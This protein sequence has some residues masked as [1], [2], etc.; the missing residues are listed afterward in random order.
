MPRYIRPRIAGASVFFTVA[1]ADRSSKALIEHIDVLRS[2]VQKTRLERP[3]H[4]NA[5]VVLPD[6]LHAVWTLPEDDCDYATRWSLI[7]ARM[8]RQMPLCQRRQSHIKRREHGF[9]QRRFWEHHI[10]NEA[11]MAACVEYC[12]YNPVKHGFVDDVQD[13]PYSSWH[14][15]NGRENGAP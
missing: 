10:R 8:S 9:W 5:W 15:D 4:I 12:W 14:K 3:F 6:H 11:E 1:L 2:A 7:K 13:W